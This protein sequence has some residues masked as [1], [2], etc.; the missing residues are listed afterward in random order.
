MHATTAP[1]HPE[2]RQLQQGPTQQLAS[3][4]ADRQAAIAAQAAMAQM[5]V[6]A[7]FAEHIATDDQIPEQQ[8]SRKEQ[9]QAQ[10]N[11]QQQPTA[12]S[13]DCA[14]AKI[15]ISVRPCVRK[16]FVWTSLSFVNFHKGE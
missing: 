11:C 12:A 7:R 16:C 2:Q 14:K 5:Q 1:I 6:G 8:N 3:L 9:L 13:Q 4:K 10:S 15:F